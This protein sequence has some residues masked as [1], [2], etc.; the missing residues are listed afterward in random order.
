MAPLPALSVDIR[1]CADDVPSVPAWFAE[2]ILLARHFTQRGVLDAISEHVRLARG[3]ASHYDVIDFVAVL[4][5]YGLSGESTLE[6]FFDRLQPFAGSFM[7]LFGRDRL[8]HR[9]T[10]SRFLADVE[11]ACLEALLQQFA[12]D[13]CRHSFTDELLGGLVDH[14]GHRLLVFDVDG[15]RQAARQ[16]TL[17]SAPEFPKRAAGWLRSVRLATS[18]ANAARS[19]ARVPPCSKR[20]R[21]SG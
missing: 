12:H 18:V 8:P 5:G 7:A 4:L 21:N 9:S 16:R 15:T 13:L 6:A 19:C 2:L 14:S 17:V 10:L 3:R 1:T 20:I 11:V